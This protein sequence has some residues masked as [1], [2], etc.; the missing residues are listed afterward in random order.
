MNSAKTTLFGLLFIFFISI[1]LSAQNDRYQMYVVHEDHV[2][3]NMK[4]KHHD[5]DKAIVKAA[6]DHNMKGMDWITFVADDNRVMYLSPIKNMAELD[7]NPFEDL[8]KKMG[9]DALEKLFDKYD[10]TYSKHGDYILRLDN[11]LSYMPDGMTTT[12]ANEDYREL[13]FYHIPPG[14]G[15]KAEELARSVKK[16]YTDMGSDIHYRLYKSGFGNMGNYYMVAVAAK[17]PEDMERKRK[18]NMDLLGE[19][20]EAMF[21][22]IENHFADIEKVTGYIR[23]ELSYVNN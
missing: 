22:E 12:P 13:T 8:G 15:E 7:N 3:E 4:D 21:D 10:G 19:K 9:G 23:P 16:M 17:S 5:A 14:K 18:E 20:G 1:S 6:K 11:E 2:N